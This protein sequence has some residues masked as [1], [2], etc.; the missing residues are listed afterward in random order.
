LKKLLDLQNLDLK[1]EKFRM[2]E[3][4]IP[5]QKNRFDIH[6]KRLD[7]ELKE[8]EA[9]FKGLMLEQRECETDISVKEEEI[10]KKDGQLIAVKKNE[11]YQA[12]LH[13]IELIKKQIGVKEERI[14]TIMEQMDDAKACFEEDKQRIAGELAEIT[15]ECGKIDDELAVAVGEREKLEAKR[16]PLIEAIDAGDLRKYERIRRAKKSGAA[17]VP[18][19]GESCSGCFMGITA[20]NVNEILGG[21]FLPCHHCGR[22]VY[23]ASKFEEE[24]VEAA[25]GGH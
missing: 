7:D 24:A 8:S 18:L 6:R 11:E 1:I 25:E 10:K 14:L 13:E 17:L 9:K 20:Q 16:V 4:E 15:A 22:L 21:A 12:L 23:F 3:T 5:K 2:R 19:Q